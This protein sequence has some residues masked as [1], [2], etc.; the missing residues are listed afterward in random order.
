[1]SSVTRKEAQM[2]VMVLDG[3]GRPGRPTTMCLRR[4]AVHDSRVHV[5]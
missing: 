2:R 5:R 1:M 3:D 4:R